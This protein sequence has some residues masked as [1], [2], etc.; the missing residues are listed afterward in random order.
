MKVASTE[1]KPATAVPCG[2]NRTTNDVGLASPA[3]GRL[4]AAAVVLQL[5]STVPPSD[6]PSTYVLLVLERLV[7]SISAAVMPLNE[8]DV[9]SPMIS[10]AAVPV[11]NVEPVDEIAMAYSFMVSGLG[12]SNNCDR[13]CDADGVGRDDLR[14]DRCFK[15]CA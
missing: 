9:I 6:V 13:A 10:P 1:L 2:P 12:A 15:R 8:I 14:I 11:L 5:T 3:V 7:T 4:G